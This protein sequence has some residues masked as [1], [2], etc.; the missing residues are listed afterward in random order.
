MF[1][2]G[3]RPTALLKCTDVG[4][5]PG[6]SG[7]R[8]AFDEGASPAKHTFAALPECLFN[9]TAFFAS[10][11]AERINKFAPVYMRV[12]GHLAIGVRDDEVLL[13]E[14]SCPGH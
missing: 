9:R 7:L 2:V 11:H 4:G 12:H 10:C 1:C 14:L 13:A 3:P 5:E 6:A 8:K